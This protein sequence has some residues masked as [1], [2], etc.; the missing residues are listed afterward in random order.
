[1]LTDAQI[2]VVREI[3]KASEENNRLHPI[4][5]H[6]VTNFEIRFVGSDKEPCTLSLVMLA[7]IYKKATDPDW[8][9]SWITR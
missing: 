3:K 7:E 1:M 9:P 6:W 2:E 5:L 4:E 8:K